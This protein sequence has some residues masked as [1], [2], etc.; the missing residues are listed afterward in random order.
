MAND[1]GKRRI[2]Q[3][4]HQITLQG[5]TTLS[6]SGV[7]EVESFDENTISLSTQEGYLMIRGSDLHIEKLNLDG[8]ELFVEGMVDSMSYE[9]QTARSVGLFTRLFRA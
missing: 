7:E 9:E 3:S 4:A 1:E 6:I 5:R 2:G 8:G